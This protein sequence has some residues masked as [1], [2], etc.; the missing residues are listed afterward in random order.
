MKLALYD[1]A[2]RPATYDIVPFA[3]TVGAIAGAGPVHFVILVDQLRD[4]SVKDRA[5]TL[6]QK[7]ARVRNIIAPCCRLLPGSAV[8]VE[9]DPAKAREWRRR[10]DALRPTGFVAECNRQWAM[11][12]DVRRLRAVGP[13]PHPGAVVIT[14]RQSPIVPAKNCDLSEWL[15]A[16]SVLMAEGHEVVLVPDTAMADRALPAGFTWCRDA[17]LDVAVRASLYQEAACSLS[18]GVGPLHIAMHMPKARYVAFVNHRDPSVEGRTIFERVFG[19]RWGARQLPF[20]GP[21]Q[22]I[23]YRRDDEGVIV[24]AFRIVQRH[25]AA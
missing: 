24:D 14:I 22:L 10:A 17:A 19:V 13:S 4:A 23:D 25:A 18:M 6:D 8:T 5:M 12:R 21:G 3:A 1:M 11:G 2:E 15:G 9:A 16:A 7:R 20:A